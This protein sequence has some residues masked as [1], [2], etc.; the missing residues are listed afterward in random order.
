[1]AKNHDFPSVFQ[2]LNVGPITLK[3]R[4]HFAPMVSAHADAETRPCHP[5]FDRIHRRTGK[6]R[7]IPDYDWFH[8][9][10]FFPRAGLHGM[11]LSN[12]SIL[13]FPG[14]TLLAEEA[15]RYGA[16]S[17]ANCNMQEE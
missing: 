3:N 12:K 16:K 2:P 9:G 17:P 15:H 14:L 6:K 5:R 1:M 10:G 13:M 4:L 8:T 7:R 11:S